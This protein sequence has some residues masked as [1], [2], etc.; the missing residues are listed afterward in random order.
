MR[1]LIQFLGISS[2]PF[3]VGC[4]ST[5]IL[6]VMPQYLYPDQVE[7]YAWA[8]RIGK[9]LP[10]ATWENGGLSWALNVWLEWKIVVTLPS[11]R[12]CWVI[13]PFPEKPREALGILPP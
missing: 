12:P 7:Q 6:P 2:L 8:R 1:R 13:P 3:L 5:E 10:C 11:F 4:I 9:E